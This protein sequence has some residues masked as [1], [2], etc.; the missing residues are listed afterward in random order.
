MQRSLVSATCPPR[1]DTG[2]FTTIHALEEAGFELIDGIQTFL[3]SLDG[4]HT[5]APPGTRLFEPEGPAGSP[6]NRQDCFRLR[7]LSTPIGAFAYVPTKSTKAGRG[8]AASESVADAVVIAEEEGRVASYVTCRT[9]RQGEARDH[10][11]GC[12]RRMGTWREAPPGERVRPRSTGSPARVWSPSRWEH[13][14]AISPLPASMK[15]SGS[16]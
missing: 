13:N 2:D 9:D 16:G 4:D 12:H 14:S 10:H 5:S 1:V 3:L 11:S 8:T 15:A 6:R 7:P